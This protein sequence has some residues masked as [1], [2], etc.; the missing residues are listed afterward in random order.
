MKRT[1][2]VGATIGAVMLPLMALAENTPGVTKTEIKI[3]ATYPFSGP[4]SAYAATGRGVIAYIDYLNDKGGINGRKINFIALDDAYSPPKAVEQVRRLVEN[5]EVAFIFGLLGTPSNAA[6]IKYLNS[7]KIPDLFIFSGGSKFTHFKEYPYT[8]TGIPSYMIEGRIYAKYIAEKM[9]NAK[10]ALLYQN[11]DLGKD[12][13]NALKAHFKDNFDKKVTAVSYE[14]TEPTID[15]Q[16][17]NLK[18]SGA[19]VFIIATTPK[20]AAQALRK[21]NEID[22]KPVRLLNA[23]SSSIAMT[24]KPVGL[25]MSTGVITAAFIKDALDPKNADDPA[26]KWYREMLTKY[27]P[28]VDVSDLNFITGVNEGMILEQ[29]LKQC[30]DD[31]SRE[32]VLKQS[33][34]I[35]D[36]QLPLTLPGILVNTNENNSQA[37][38]QLQLQ[39]FNGA[40]WERFGDV[41]G[42][43]PD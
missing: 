14:V 37:F 23:V 20:F 18:N 43:E 4:A 7:K 25:D 33:R 40:S 26:L 12:F 8:T 34:N 31:V 11:D 27:G 6:T 1:F 32:N 41:V 38:T 16:V 42:V 35:K 5:E 17:V 10:I 21:A 19:D 39:R 13:L 15:S 2:L 3:G 30:G 24:L 28:G 22:W 9:P 36:L 29:V